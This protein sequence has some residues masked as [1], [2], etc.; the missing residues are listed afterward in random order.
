MAY[1]QAT[2]PLH[3][4]AGA[5][6][7][8]IITRLFAALLLTLCLPG[9]AFAADAV[10]EDANT[11]PVRVVILDKLL[12]PP[13]IGLAIL[14]NAASQLEVE[15]RPKSAEIQALSAQLATAQ[16]ALLK[17][18]QAGQNDLAAIARAD[19]LA[20]ELDRNSEDAGLAY[21]RRQTAVFDPLVQEID[22]AL[23]R[24]AAA[25]PGGDAFLLSQEEFNAEPPGTLI[26]IS[27][28]FVGWMGTQ[29]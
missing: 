18:E 7:V 24:Y 8:T 16:E 6:A 5:G 28:Q 12:E 13:P 9:Q 29:P 27:A 14:S 22:V 10:V 17:A 25:T 26:D 21:Q 3:H 1:R 4:A 2:G 19:T 23:Q 15:F 11:A 20:S